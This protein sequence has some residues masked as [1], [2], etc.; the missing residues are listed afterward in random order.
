MPP[1]KLVIF[2]L[3]TKS[4]IAF[5]EYLIFLFQLN[6]RVNVNEKAPSGNTP[7]HAAINT[8]N[9]TM[10]K[11]LIDAGANVNAWNPECEGAAPLHLAIMSGKCHQYARIYYLTLVSSISLVLVLILV[12]YSFRY[13]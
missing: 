13:F 1:T 3:K 5:N 6:P 9:I 7:L 12:S 4:L 10:V 2:Y 11:L 8:G